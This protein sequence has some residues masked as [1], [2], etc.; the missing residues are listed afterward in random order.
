M[1]ISIVNHS[2]TI[3]DSKL[4]PV[5]R[6]INRQ[7]RDDFE[8]HWGR[9]ALL[10]LEGRSKDAPGPERASD[11]RGEAVVYLCD[12]P[13]DAEDALGY[14]ELTH[15][16]IPYGF[17]FTELSKELRE[18]WS[19]TLSH[20]VLELVLDPE[21]NL[22][23]KGPHPE[24]ATREVFHWY[25]ACDAV[26]T[27]W[28]EIDGV[29][30]SNFVLPLYFT[31]NEE[32]GGRNDFLGARRNGAPL[33]S[34][35]VA[36]GGYVG[37]FDPDAGEDRFYEADAEASARNALKRRA[38][39]A[40]RGIRYQRNTAPLGHIDDMVGANA[41]PPRLE[42]ISLRMRGRAPERSVRALAARVLGSGWKVVANPASPG[43]FDLLPGRRQLEV[44]RA[45]ELAHQLNRTPGVLYA[46]PLF[47]AQLPDDEG[48]QEVIA[49]RLGKM[50][51]AG[52]QGIIDNAP[53]DSEWSVQLVRAEGAWKLLDAAGIGYGA[54]VRIGHPDTGFTSHPEL[55]LAQIDQVDDYDFVDDDA[56]A[57]DPLQD[58]LFRHPGHGTA[59]SSVILSPRGAQGTGYRNHV[60]GIA[61]AATLVP[62]RVSR[63]V[64][65]FSQ[66]NLRD[67]IDRAVTAGCHVISV[68][69]GGLPSSSLHEAIGRAVARGVIV[70]A[71][72]G[73]DVRLVVWPARYEE[74]VAVAACN[75]RGQPW[76]GSSRG[77]AV[78]VT[79]PGEGVYRA[80]WEEDPQTGGMRATVGPSDGT[81]YATATVA[82]MAA[83]WLAYHGVANLQA[84][85]PGAALPLAFAAL[86]A[87]TC[88]TDL[89]LPEDFGRGVV[90]AERLLRAPLPSAATLSKASRARRAAKDPGEPLERL[91]SL[92]PRVDPAVA[93]D[94]L[95]EI[96]GRP[97]RAQLARLHDELRFWLALDPK[98][99]ATVGAHLEIA[100]TERRRARS[101]AGSTRAR[102]Q[103][104]VNP[105]RARAD[106]G[107]MHR[108]RAAITAS[109]VSRELRETLWKN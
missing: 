77:D 65:Q 24:D 67:A 80:H 75:E 46:E 5:I 98:L 81:S 78:D 31:S 76:S 60:T 56:S 2:A 104:P 105:S 11:I 74:V 45:W 87:S 20:E 53:K 49:A 29:R 102:A 71:A 30:V 72:A 26:Q 82:G 96:L 8:P 14:H 32:P 58:G 47:E 88:R 17:V 27:Q 21:V 90:D 100:D 12:R 103:Q 89:T 37:Y 54:G 16:G 86:L 63:S 94:G 18:P 107:R 1:L 51:R 9:E 10:R 59:T 101:A 23:V 84:R 79:G 25:E 85:Y 69:L 57:I 50:L 108:V 95:M 91:T 15:R 52:R 68:C 55:P 44:A 73:N 93:R 66:K 70:I 62:L 4:H 61:P 42:S 6:A 33:A 35:G 109:A 7:L 97:A 83:L 13:S 36:P 41:P 99:H 38:G 39:L 48:R 43:A 3:L 22:L 19:I 64:I 34:F 106:R 28:Y 40:R 92:F